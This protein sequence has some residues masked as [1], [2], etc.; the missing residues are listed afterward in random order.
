MGIRFRCPNG[1]KLNVKEIDPATGRRVVGKIGYC[2]KCG[3]RFR[4]P[5]GGQAVAE[6]SDSSVLDDPSPVTAPDDSAALVPAQGPPEAGRVGGR[7][8]GR[9]AVVGLA[10][11]VPASSH[12]TGMSPRADLE[13]PDAATLPPVPAG[14][15]VRWPAIDEAPQAIWYVRPP[16]GGQYGPARGDVMR[17]WLLEGRVPEDALVWREGWPDWETA[18]SVFPGLTALF[19]APQVGPD[20]PAAYPPPPPSPGAPVP[21]EAVPLGGTASSRR[22]QASGLTAAAVPRKRRVW[23]LVGVLAGLCLAVGAVLVY[24]LIRLQ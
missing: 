3:A 5:P 23:H 10:S 19:A 4:I 18:G 14:A 21:K 15:P 7:V 17:Q 22:R 11:P 16:T 20:A 13:K 1:H 24:L 6:P 2:P 8:G 12:A 9:E